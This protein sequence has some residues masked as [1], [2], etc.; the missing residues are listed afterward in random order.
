VKGRRRA[1][2]NPVGATNVGD[3][4]DGVLLEHFAVGQDAG[5]FSALVQRFGP[6]VLSVCRRVLHH[7]QDAEDAFQATFLV[8]ARKAGSIRKRESVGS[9]LYGVA[10]RIARQV[11][12]RNVRRQAT[13]RQLTDVP[14]ETQ[15]PELARHELRETLDAEVNRLPV[16]YRRPFVLYYVEGK[17]KEQVAQEL[18]CPLGTV[19]SRLGRARDR[20]RSRLTRRGVALSAGL[21]ATAL[22]EHMAFAVLPAP[23]TEATVTAALHFV[24]ASSTPAGVAS[25]NVTALAKSFLKAL[26]RRT[27]KKAAAG[28]LSLGLVAIV[29]LLLTTRRAEV[30]R[31]DNDDLDGSWKVD[32][33]AFNGDDLPAEGLRVV[34][35]GGRFRLLSGAQQAVSVRYLRDPA[36]EPKA[37]DLVTQTG[38]SWPGIYGREGEVLKLSYNCGDQERPLGFDSKPTPSTSPTAKVFSYVLRR[39]SG[40]KRPDE[41]KSGKAGS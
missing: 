19:V 7:E 10:Y 3:L 23:L 20:L 22:G 16:K 26:F 39:E 11:R 9:W 41:T 12:S 37:I 2:A 14:E 8:L 1:S 13:Q 6:L 35:A 34:F 17:T 5:A 4:P 38:Q 30:A 29:L 27:L 36:K 21:L 40:D 33:V 31:P 18:R 15:P 32:A 25:G 24:G 28:L